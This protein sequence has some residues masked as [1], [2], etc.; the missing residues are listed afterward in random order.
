MQLLVEARVH[1]HDGRMAETE[2]TPTGFTPGDGLLARAFHAAPN[3]FVLVDTEG[4]IVAA[5]SEL[6]SMFGCSPES[7]IGSAIDQLL[8][9]AA[10]AAHAVQRARFFAAPERRPMGAER[11]LHARRA[12][13]DEFPIEVGLNPVADARGP[14]VLAS[15]VD[16]SARLAH[17]SALQGLFDASPCGLAIVDDDGL[18]A[19]AN[20]ALGDSLGYEPSELAE[21]PLHILLP[22][23]YRAGHAGLM[24]GYH[25]GGQ[26]RTMGLGRDLCALHRDGN[27]VPVEVG[28]S[29]V[30]WRRQTMT[31]AAITNI[32]ARKRLEFELRQANANLQEFTYAAS[33]DLRSPLRGIVDLLDWVQADLGQAAPAE[34]T[35]NLGRIGQRVQRMERLIDDLLRLT[36]AGR[37]TTA[38]ERVDLEALA[39]AVLE[40]HPLP[41][42][43]ELELRI[44]V[45]PFQAARAPL[46]TVL[47]NLIANAVAHHD[48]GAGRVA[49]VAD[50]Q[51]DL[52][53]ISVIDDGPGI[54]AAAAQ[55]IFQLFQTLH[56]ADHASPG[57]G[58]ALT[59]RIVE[60]HGG[61]IDVLSPLIDG[62]GACFRVWWPRFPRRTDHDARA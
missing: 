23:R 19:M 21:R 49:I 18:I 4:R 55:R 14:L 43:F 48:R 52:C 60:A 5:N 20:R 17:E 9:E 27:E 46:E 36:R 34:V 53:E 57:V 42:G 39:R 22:E 6:A 2:H 28:L 45:A 1:A 51:R 11:V 35:R 3:G 41:P 38:F 13:G 50:E 16:V 25:A 61:R 12:N 62:R 7:L 40:R 26:A 59:R 37:T 56:G 24:H 8:P 31:L 29:R 15:V 10:R 58:L 32:G 54:P 33:H 44:A 47:G 30:T